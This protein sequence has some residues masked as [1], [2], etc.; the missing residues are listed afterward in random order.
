MYWEKECLRLQLTSLVLLTK[1]SNMDIVSLPQK[2]KRIP[3][4]KHRYCGCFPSDYVAVIVRTATPFLR[5]FIVAAAKR[6]GVDLLESVV[7]DV[8]EVVGG[9]KNFKTAAKSVGR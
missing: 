3:L 2:T 8:A 1:T 5:K 6:V 4:L 7:P 9:R